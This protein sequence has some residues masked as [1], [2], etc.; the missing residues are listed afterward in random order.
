MLNL[1]LPQARDMTRIDKKSQDIRL[2]VE[3]DSVEA[4]SSDRDSAEKNRQVMYLSPLLR[5]LGKF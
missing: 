4:L 1:S 2:R 3:D 5:W